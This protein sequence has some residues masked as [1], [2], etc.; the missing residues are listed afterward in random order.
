MNSKTIL[1]LLFVIFS[2]TGQYVLKSSGKADSVQ[3]KIQPI[4]EKTLTELL[5]DNNKFKLLHFWGK[6]CKGQSLGIEHKLNFTKNKF[7]NLKIIIIATDLYH[8]STLR[9]IYRLCKKYKVETPIYVFNTE[10]NLLNE[11]NIDSFATSKPLKIKN[12][13]THLDSLCSEISIPYTALLDTMGNIIDSL[14]PLIIENKYNIKDFNKIRRL[15][16]KELK[17]FLSKVQ[18]IQKNKKNNK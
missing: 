2:L 9:P 18:S 10:E 7:E 1:I 8:P 15:Y 6:W 11:G 3:C 17:N 16:I 12:I 13:I 4:N 14:H 5:T